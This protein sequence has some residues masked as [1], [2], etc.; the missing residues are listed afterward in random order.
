MKSLLHLLFIIAPTFLSAQCQILL[1]DTLI[2]T[3]PNDSFVI[4]AVIPATGGAPIESCD[5]NSGLP[6]GWSVAGLASFGQGC[7]PSLDGTD[8]YWASTAAGST[9][10]V[11][12]DAVSLSCGGFIS[13]DLVYA[14]QGAASPCEGPDS[15]E[16]GV[17]IQYSTDGG[18]TWVTFSYFAPSGTILPLNPGSGGTGTST[19]TP[20][21]TWGNYTID[22]PI[23]IAT[24][25]AQFRWI[26]NFSSGPDFDNWGLDNIEVV[27]YNCS[28]TISWSTGATNTNTINVS[29]P[30]DTF[31]IA[32]N[33]DTLGILQCQDTCFVD[34][35]GTGYD[36]G[37]QLVTETFTSGWNSIGFIDAY[38]IG[39]TP[40]SG[41]ITLVLDTML[42]FV[43]S[44]PPPLNVNGDTL[45]FDYSG[46]TL[47]SPHHIIQLEYQCSVFAQVGDS[48]LIDLL[49]E[50]TLGDNN[51]LNNE[52]NY[53]FPVMASYDPNDKKVYPTGDCF[54]GYVLND[55]LLTY[56]IRFQNTG[57][58]AATDVIIRDELMGSLNPATLKVVAAS[59]DVSEDWISSDIVE[60]KFDSIMLPDESAD[61]IGSIGYII[62]EIEQ[63]PTLAHGT[64]ITNDVE[65]F[66]D[67][68]PPVLTNEVLNTVSDGTHIVIG[69][70]LVAE[71]D[72][73][74]FW[75][76][77]VLNT[78][79]LYSQIFS[80]S[81]GCDSTV[82]LDLTLLSSN[83]ILEFE[84]GKLKLYPNPAKEYVYFQG[85]E[86][87]AIVELYDPQ[88]KR[89]VSRNI[90]AGEKMELG[91]I[92]S[93]LYL[94]NCFVDGVVYH[95][96]IIIEK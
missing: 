19:P 18:L 93:G 51:V 63:T 88:G 91:E 28:N 86:G 70:T 1:S 44:T 94:V 66:F 47:N 13:F 40:T 38:N 3:C 60:F 4:T 59:H 48:V 15:T 64:A 26:Q 57:T 30:V 33:Y 81:N 6:A 56:T 69:D 58:A 42:T 29:S 75:Q 41:N 35:L 34:I 67:N 23:V 49:I 24:A 39:C 82:F 10:F 77:N 27:S 45:I 90:Q 43:S 79:G 83:S 87:L 68:N 21:T 54:P 53:I 55:Q 37:A 32:Y 46:L 76:G 50:D 72:S 78:S 22:I 62:F 89:I 80:M 61:P 85:F 36:N 92:S 12:T 65:I 73:L 71:A 25:N 9:P 8:Y 7:G 16:E 11:A 2:T 31:Y 74:Y 5:F 20:F 96:R 84:N 17:E 52:H 95:S 14:L